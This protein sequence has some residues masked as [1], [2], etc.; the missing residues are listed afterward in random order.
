M[1]IGTEQCVT[2]AYY[3]EVRQ[4]S[5]LGFPPLIKLCYAK[6]ESIEVISP[7]LTCQDAL[8][9]QADKADKFNQYKV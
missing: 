3:E 7:W 1:A 4:E 9:V 2:C 6:E 5:K 8:L